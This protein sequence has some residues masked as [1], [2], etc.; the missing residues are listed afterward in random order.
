MQTL[1]QGILAVALIVGTGAACT[2]AVCLWRVAQISYRTWAIRRE[3]RQVAR[4]VDMGCVS[5][6]WV[7]HES[8]KA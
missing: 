1:V 8:W 4:E 3:L 5:P 2:L 7:S 6:R